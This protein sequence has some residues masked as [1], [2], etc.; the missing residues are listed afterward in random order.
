MENPV[1]LGNQIRIEIKP[2]EEYPNHA[3]IMAAI[4]DM[5]HR[6]LLLNTRLNHVENTGDL[7]ALDLPERD[8]H[9]SEQ[10]VV[11]L[12]VQCRFEYHFQQELWFISEVFET[13]ALPGRPNEIIVAGSP[14]QQLDMSLQDFL[15][16]LRD[17]W[18]P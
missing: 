18:A 10:T 4:P 8:T 17:E 14:F 16:M 13:S 9:S 6:V 12:A 11:E 15:D 1:I 5:E 3:Q 2:S 7:S